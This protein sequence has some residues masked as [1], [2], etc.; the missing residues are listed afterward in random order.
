MGKIR[1]YVP[2]QSGIFGE[3]H[4]KQG[5]QVEAATILVQ[6]Q[7]YELVNLKYNY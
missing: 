5:T 4:S 3:D 7:V 1:V 2:E 6:Q